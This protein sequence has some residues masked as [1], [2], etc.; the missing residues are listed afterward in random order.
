M[1]WDKGS[2][3]APAP[4]TSSD[5]VLPLNSQTPMWEL[6]FC[7]TL[8]LSLPGRSFHGKVLS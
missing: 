2:L 1:T 4:A 3:P 5:A 7:S 8:N 6:L